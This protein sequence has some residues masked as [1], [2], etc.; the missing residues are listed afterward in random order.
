[1]MKPQEFE[2]QNRV[3]LGAMQAYQSKGARFTMNDLAKELGMSK[4]TIYT[5]F[6][7]KESLLLAMVDYFFDAIKESKREVAE[8]YKHLPIDEQFIALLGVMPGNS[9]DIDFTEIYQMRDKYPTVY[10]R[11]QHRLES[12]WE[13]TL[14]LLDEGVKQG[15][16]RDVDRLVFQLTFEAAVERFLTGNELLENKKDYNEV[17]QELVRIMVNGIRATR[18]SN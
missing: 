3:I 7:D 13:K 14:E 16:F 6:P 15:V 8:N 2:L 9:S 4:K 17:L 5:V 12:D 11:V 1:M 10:E 18:G